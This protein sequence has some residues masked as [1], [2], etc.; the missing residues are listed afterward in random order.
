MRFQAQ[1]HNS[2]MSYQLVSKKYGRNS[3]NSVVLLQNKIEGR[4]MSELENG[5]T[6]IIM[7]AI[8]EH[9]RHNFYL[10]KISC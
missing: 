8:D 4:S 6:I 3:F 2:Y 7:Y 5:E 10:I 9:P 1:P